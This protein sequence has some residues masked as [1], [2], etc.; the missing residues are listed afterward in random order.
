LG[1]NL[2]HTI[3]WCHD[4]DVSANFLVELLGLAAPTRFGPFL[5][6]DEFITR[7]YGRGGD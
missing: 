1:V 4:Q 5:V 7:R 6:V 3:V 2:D